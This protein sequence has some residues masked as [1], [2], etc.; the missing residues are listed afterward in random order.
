VLTVQLFPQLPLNCHT[1]SVVRNNVLKLAFE[2]NL[3]MV[4]Q[5]KTEISDSRLGEHEVRS[6]GM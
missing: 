5:K 2:H 3:L 1:G 6:L 4:K